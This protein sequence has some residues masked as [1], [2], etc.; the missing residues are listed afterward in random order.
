MAICSL[1]SFNTNLLFSR[2]FRRKTVFLPQRRNF[3]NL[4]INQTFI[5]KHHGE[6]KLI[7]TI[8]VTHEIG[9]F[10]SS[11]SY[12]FHC[13]L[14]RHEKWVKINHFKLKSTFPRCFCFAIFSFTAD[15]AQ[16]DNAHECKKKRKKL[17]PTQFNKLYENIFIENKHDVCNIESGNG[18]KLQIRFENK[19]NKFAYFAFYF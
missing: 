4:T 6:N 10:T 16:D 2:R 1:A 8:P 13:C 12:V 15:E 17:T 18:P 11:A 14:K 7:I 5:S 9:R 3:R 19:E